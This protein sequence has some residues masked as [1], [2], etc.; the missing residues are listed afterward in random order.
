MVT[1]VNNSRTYA[2]RGLK[3]DEKP[4][5]SSIG[6]GSTFYEMDTGKLYF[7]DEENATWIGKEDWIEDQ[8][9]AING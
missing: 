4:I 9:E 6:N 7:Y 8:E 2:L 5:N 3:K 1:A